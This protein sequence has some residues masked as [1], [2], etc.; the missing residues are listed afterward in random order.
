MVLLVEF[1]NR[2]LSQA[3]TGCGIDAT[4][5]A[6]YEGFAARFSELTLNKSYAA[7]DFK[8]WID[9]RQYA[10]FFTDLV[11]HRFLSCKQCQ[12]FGV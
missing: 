10:H 12:F 5:D 2:K 11:F 9:R 4:T 8:L 7:F 1:F 6:Q 3:T